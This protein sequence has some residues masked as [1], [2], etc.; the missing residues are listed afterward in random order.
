MGWRDDHGGMERWKHREAAD[1]GDGQAGIPLRLGADWGSCQGH[2]RAPHLP[3]LAS[4][5]VWAGA[6]VIGWS[7]I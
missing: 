7:G 6:G 2:R 5:R 4:R 1:E 3:G